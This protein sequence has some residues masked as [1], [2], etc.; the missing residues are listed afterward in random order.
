MSFYQL[1]PFKVSPR[2]MVQGTPEY[3][4]GS[5]PTDVAPTQGVVLSDSAATTTATV[6]VKIYQGNIPLPGSLITIV[7]SANSAGIFNVTNATILTVSAP[8]PVDEGVYT[9]TFAIAS[10]TQATTID[11]GLF[12]VP[13]P[14]VGDALTA[15]IVAA[16]PISSAP[17]VSPVA[18]PNS[19]GKSLSCTITLPAS[20]AAI[21]STLAGVTVVLQG[22]N[23]DL[24]GQYNTVGTIGV[25]MLA[26]NTYEWQ[27]GQ[28]D[29]TAPS[30]SLAIGNV[31]L[32]NFRFYRVQ[33]TAA[34][35]AGPIVAK[36]LQ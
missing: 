9:I 12:M 18:G 34:T 22:A 19:V 23:F 8:A 10:T 33:V 3:M 11:S 28:G 17:I 2:L 21:P 32:P 30:N 5:Y 16:L 27:S 14:E 7:G 25:G 15:A 31:N 35:G 1:T 13:Q 24:D 26:G 6:T 20:T 36:L 29:P 4:L